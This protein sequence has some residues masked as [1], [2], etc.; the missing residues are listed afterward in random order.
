MTAAWNSANAKCQVV[1]IVNTNV[2]HEEP[3]AA[4]M[5]DVLTKAYCGPT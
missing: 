2:S 4:A 5:R 3:I 1:V